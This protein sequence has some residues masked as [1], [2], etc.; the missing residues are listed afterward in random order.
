MNASNK[1]G[2][3]ISSKTIEQIMENEPT[4]LISNDSPDEKYDKLV[5][6]KGIGEVNAKTFIK[7]IPVFMNFLHECGLDNKMQ[8]KPKNSTHSQGQQE[9]Q[10]IHDTSNPLYNKKVVMTKVRDKDI[11]EYLKEIGGILQDNITSDTFIL[12]VKSKDDNSS[13]MVKA[14]EKGIIIMTPD[15]FKQEFII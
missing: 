4:I 2:R 12:I 6:I 9:Q 15:E 11:I 1:L 8:F 14:K 13:K 3:G 10:H 7:N 5:K